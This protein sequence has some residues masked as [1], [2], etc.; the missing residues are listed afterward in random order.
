MKRKDVIIMNT[1][2]R[3]ATIR[4]MQDIERDPNFSS[5]LVVGSFT[6]T[7]TVPS[8]KEHDIVIE[9]SCCQKKE[10][11]FCHSILKNQKR[12]DE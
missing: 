11:T 5:E 2:E 12:K 8:E 4:M 7:K 1:S 9:R 6:T 3:I 10:R